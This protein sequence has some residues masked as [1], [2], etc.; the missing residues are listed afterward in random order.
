MPSTV[1]WYTANIHQLPIK[2]IHS[3]VKIW[4]W[5]GPDI[6]RYYY[7][8]S[9]VWLH[10]KHTWELQYIRPTIVV[11]TLSNQWHKQLLLW[12][13]FRLLEPKGFNSLFKSS[14]LMA[15][16]SVQYISVQEFPETDSTTMI[17]WGMHNTQA[18]T[19]KL[20]DLQRLA[21]SI[22]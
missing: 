2:W 10:L 11:Y 7:K 4:D 1:P 15:E 13:P 3:K 5:L 9:H 21:W 16:M 20:Q 12:W 22:S 8:E 17:F 18:K 6:L 19:I 14:L